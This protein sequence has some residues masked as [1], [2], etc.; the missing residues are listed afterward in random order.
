MFAILLAYYVY[1]Y[2]KK[3]ME[4]RNL[5]NLKPESFGKFVIGEPKNGFVFYAPNTL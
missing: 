4:K 2:P 1:K 5:E 3:K